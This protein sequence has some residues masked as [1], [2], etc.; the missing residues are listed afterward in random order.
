MVNE[1]GMKHQKS[2]GWLIYFDGQMMLIGGMAPRL[3]GSHIKS[4]HQTKVVDPM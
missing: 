3:L 2:Y 1:R 4:G